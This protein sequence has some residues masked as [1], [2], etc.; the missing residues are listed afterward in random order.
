MYNKPKVSKLLH[1]KFQIIGGAILFI[2]IGADINLQ[3][4]DDCGVTRSA[5]SRWRNT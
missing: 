1:Q 5:S 4:H 3:T 2:V